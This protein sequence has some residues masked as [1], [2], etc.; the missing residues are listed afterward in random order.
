MRLNRSKERSR[1]SGNSRGNL[2]KS[3]RKVAKPV[4]S[5][6][7]SF[8]A[9]VDRANLRAERCAYRTYRLPALA[10]D[11]KPPHARGIY[12]ARRLGLH[13]N[14][15]GDATAVRRPKSGMLFSLPEPGNV[16]E[17]FAERIL[18]FAPQPLDAIPIAKENE[19]HRQRKKRLI[20]NYRI[21]EEP[22]FDTD[23]QTIGRGAVRFREDSSSQSYPMARAV[24]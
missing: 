10:V 11:D 14:L 18:K 17:R 22:T 4:A 23:S 7:A 16:L 15:I 2:P 3:F 20:S 6:D 19:H 21:L 8:P 5:R 24:P 13:H 1:G 12:G 9:N